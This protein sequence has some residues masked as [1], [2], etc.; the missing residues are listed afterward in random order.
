MT[1]TPV[2]LSEVQREPSINIASL[3]AKID[4]L[5]PVV[6]QSVSSIRERIRNAMLRGDVPKYVEGDSVL[7]AG[8][9]FSVGK[10]WSSRWRGP[11]GIVK[12]LNDYAYQVEGLRNGQLREVHGIRLWF[13][14]D[15]AM[16]AE[17][18]MSHVVSSE[19]GMPVPRLIQLVDSD[20]WVM[21]QIC[22]GGLPESE[23]TLEPVRKVNKDVSALFL[24]FLGRKNTAEY[25]VSKTRQV[26]HL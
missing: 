23:D 19:T 14:R 25:L 5:H 15:S 1:S 21:V 24:K 7:D 3:K 11:R 9:D 2:S 26:L 12:A 6:Q 10:K 20:D 17:A 13:H 16:N 4:E 18:I 8:E 22:W